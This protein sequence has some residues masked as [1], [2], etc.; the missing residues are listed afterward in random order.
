M[1][2]C[3][4]LTSELQGQICELALPQTVP[5]IKQHRVTEKSSHRCLLTAFYLQGRRLRNTARMLTGLS[6]SSPVRRRLLDD[7]AN[8]AGLI[9][10]FRQK[11]VLPLS[12][13][14]LL[15]TFAVHR[16]GLVRDVT[17]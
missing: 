9:P 8:S 11:R 13:V 4:T 3:Q 2:G 6:R 1:A 17:G 5:F 14:D 12:R 15:G 7:A 10:V 16:N